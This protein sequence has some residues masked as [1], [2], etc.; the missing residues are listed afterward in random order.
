MCEQSC[1][2][3]PLIQVWI[4]VYSLEVGTTYG[5]TFGEQHRCNSQLAS[6][7]LLSSLEAEHL[8]VQGVL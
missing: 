5:A 6:D 7:V 1:S 8:A 3:A 4:V 2:K